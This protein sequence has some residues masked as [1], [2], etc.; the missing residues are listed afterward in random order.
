MDW[1]RMMLRIRSELPPVFT[2]AIKTY[3]QRKYKP[4]LYSYKPTR[5]IVFQEVEEDEKTRAHGSSQQLTTPKQSQPRMRD[6]KWTISERQQKVRDNNKTDQGS[7]KSIDQGGSETTGMGVDE[8]GKS[9]SRKRSASAASLSLTF[10][11]K[12]KSERPCK[13]EKRYY[14]CKNGEIFFDM[15]DQG[16]HPY[17]VSMPFETCA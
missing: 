16:Y 7:S 11:K 1:M 14:P 15:P 13:K 3:H 5:N 8:N 6:L 4:V 10:G 17:L 2:E 9:V 12:K